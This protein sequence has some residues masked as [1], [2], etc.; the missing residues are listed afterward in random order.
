[1]LVCSSMI[2]DHAEVRKMSPNYKLM[3]WEKKKSKNSNSSYNPY[4]TLVMCYGSI[5]PGIA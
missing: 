5:F 1:M 3:P 4:I 2:W